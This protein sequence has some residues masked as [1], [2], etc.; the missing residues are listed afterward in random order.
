[1]RLIEK[2]WYQDHWFKWLL[3][4]LSFIFAGLS[5][6]RRIGYRWHI[7]KQPQLNLP[8][9]IVGNIGVGG[10]GKTPMVVYL[11][12]RL[13]A[14][15]YKVGV[16][17]RGY[18]GQSGHYPLLVDETIDSSQ[19]GDEP[20]LI[21]QR[22]GCPV[23]VSPDRV[24]AVNKLATLGCQLVVCDDGLQHYRLKRDVELVIVDGQRR[25]G[26]GWLMPA[27][28][29]RE[30][31]WRLNT[32]DFVIANGGKPAA[33]E[34]SM[35]LKASEFVH[36]QSGRR[37]GLDEFVEQAH[38]SR[39]HAV[40]AIGNPPRFYDSLEALGIKLEQ[41]VSFA[42]HHHYQ[43]SDFK[44]FARQDLVLM[45]EKDAVKCRSFADENWWYLAVSAQFDSQFEQRLFERI[46]KRS[47]DYG[48]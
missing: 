4:P 30:G 48:L 18:G 15:G 40:A 34:A 28:P 8:V 14:A 29:L 36:L 22:T 39:C 23:V 24:A 25:F 11:V 41:K 20:V 9:I 19:A 31:L 21:Y 32:V 45:T 37:M 35:T 27:G 12:E 10:N 3:L 2:A 33:G 43:K 47:K 26:N 7:C 17:S 1:V 5:A 44:G 13:T 38:Q 16:V 46:T 42:D 6:L